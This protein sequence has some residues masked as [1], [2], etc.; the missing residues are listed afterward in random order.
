MLASIRTATCL[1]LL[2]TFCHATFSQTTSQPAPQQSGTGTISGSV[3]IGEAPAAG[4]TLALIPDQGGR[5]AG[6]GPGQQPVATP[7]DATQGK[8][9]QT[10]TDDKGLYT[11]SGVA[12]GKYRVAL[13]ADTLVV[14]NG[15]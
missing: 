6:R 8:T 14:G 4:I 9:A 12:A 10:T 1:I 2:L 13:L 5:P 3:K 11:F 15:D 7:T